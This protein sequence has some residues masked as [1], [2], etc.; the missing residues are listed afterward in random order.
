[1]KNSTNI[2]IKLNKFAKPDQN[3]HKKLIFEGKY[4]RTYLLE[5]DENILKNKYLN[6]CNVDKIIVDK[7]KS[8]M[9][10]M[11]SSI[12]NSPENSPINSLSR[13]R[14]RITRFPSTVNMKNSATS[15]SLNYSKVNN[16]LSQIDFIPLNTK[17]KLIN[18]PNT[19]TLT[20]NKLLIRDQSPKLSKISTIFEKFNLE[21]G[22][23]KSKNFSQIKT[24]MKKI[25]NGRKLH[26]FMIEDDF[27][28]K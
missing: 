17:K 13:S 3:S 14:L 11:R 26:S 4:C 6:K 23:D 10:S 9:I 27:Y 28:Y 21:I 1:M 5:E 25:T 20:F 2:F 12:V 24:K 18:F 7:S 15:L 19:S 8:S 22:R 16:N